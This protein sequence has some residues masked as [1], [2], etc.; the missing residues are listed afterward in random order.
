MTLDDYQDSHIRETTF[1][2]FLRYVAG[3]KDIKISFST[4]IE[5]SFPVSIGIILC[6]SIYN[7]S[8]CKYN[9]KLD[10]VSVLP[11]GEKFKGS[12]NE[13]DLKDNFEFPLAS[14]GDY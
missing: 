1:N 8:L 14:D 2:I 7:D 6:T 11:L 13:D 4:T 5:A 9:E 10:Q 12:F 3:D